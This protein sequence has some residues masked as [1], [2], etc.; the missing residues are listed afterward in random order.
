MKKLAFL[1]YAWGSTFLMAAFIYWLATIPYLSAGDRVTDELV[2]ILFRMTLYAIFFILFYRSLIITLK[3]SVERLA[4]WRSK[5]EK[6]DDEEFVLII[7]TLSIII[8]ILA[9]TLFSVFEQYS[10]YLAVLNNSIA[11]RSP[12]LKDVLV[13]VIAILLTAIVVY[14]I[15]AIGEL[16]IGIKHRIQAGRKKNKI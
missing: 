10:Q 5:N 16:E 9:S 15:P 2:K 8:T 6:M 4:K 13:S 12:E 3:S 11:N 7:E 1:I 14:S